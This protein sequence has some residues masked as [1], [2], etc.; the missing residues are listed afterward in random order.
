MVSDGDK[1]GTQVSGM[2]MPKLEPNYFHGEQCPL[3]PGTLTLEGS[4]PPTNTRVGPCDL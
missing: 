4:L 3:L 2:T 1:T